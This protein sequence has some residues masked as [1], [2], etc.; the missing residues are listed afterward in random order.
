[1][2]DFFTQMVTLDLTKGRDT[3]VDTGLK[4]Y[5]HLDLPPGKYLLRILVRNAATG[6]SGVETLAVD[7]PEYEDAQPIL[8]P[9]FFVDKGKDWFLVRENSSAQT[10]KTV[11]YPFTVNGEPYI[12]AAL[13]SLT[14]R[15][16]AAVCLVAYNIGEGE[17]HL[18]S[19]IVAEDG[20]IIDSDVLALRERTITGIQG[21]DKLLATF[22]PIG[23]EA[24]NYTLEVALRNLSSGAIETSSI[25][26]SLGV[27]Q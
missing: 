15:E 22:R 18:D 25:P 14:E 12:P 2:K 19:T 17:I 21:L 8:L 26:F 9:P 11:V 7:V 4:Y 6:R 23:L 24:G 10:Q 27:S 3:F 13:P 20:E 1:M 5:G 16:E